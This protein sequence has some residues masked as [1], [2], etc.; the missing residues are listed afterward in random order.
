MNRWRRYGSAQAAPIPRGALPSCEREIRKGLALLPPE[1]RSKLRRLAKERVGLLLEQSESHL[2]SIAEGATN[3]HRHSGQ[4]ATWL[5]SLTSH[6]EFRSWDLAIRLA[7]W[8][9]LRDTEERHF[10]T[11]LAFS[12]RVVQNVL[13]LHQGITKRQAI[14]QASVRILHRWLET[15]MLDVVALMCRQATRHS[16]TFDKSRSKARALSRK[17]FP[18]TQQ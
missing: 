1:A 3:F 15:Y 12:T 14:A 13:H 6:P 9:R 5:R 16:V 7:A 2:S 8:Y 10:P 4:C 11:A 18:E 17:L